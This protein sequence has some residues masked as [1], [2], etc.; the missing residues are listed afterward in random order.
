[1]KDKTDLLR[2]LERL[3]FGDHLK[4]ATAEDL[5][6]LVCLL[7]LD[8]GAGVSDLARAAGCSAARVRGAL[9]F[10]QECGVT[11]DRTPAKKPLASARNL[12]PQTEAE[13]AAYIREHDLGALIDECQTLYGRLFNPAEISVVVGL[14]EQLG[15]DDA[16]VLTLA[17]WCVKQNKKTLRYLERIA[18]GLSDDGIDTPARLD[19]HLKRREKALSAEGRL[20]KLFGIGER[21]LSKT[22]TDCFGRWV[23]DF[24]FDMDVI[25]LAYD[26]TVDQKQ[27]ALVRYT[28]SV[29]ARWHGAGCRTLADVEA[30]LEKEKR[31]RKT[32]AAAVRGAYSPSDGGSFST[33]DF[34]ARALERSYREYPAKKPD[35]APDAPPADPKP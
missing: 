22:E 1:M 11:A 32:S 29:L 9:A 19:E 26:I 6:V 21:A 10:W 33:E 34:F 20:R 24:G 27:K 3:P 15:L 30:L 25:G 17:G 2:A 18:I 4:E 13:D 35:E 28:D 31:E 23:C 5:R 12:A 14:S 7:A 8:D 16:Y